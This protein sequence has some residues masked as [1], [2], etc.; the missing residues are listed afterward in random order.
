VAK[1]VGFGTGSDAEICILAFWS[2]LIEAV[3]SGTSVDLDLKFGTMSV[4]KG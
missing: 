2:K 1:S 3:N 4:S